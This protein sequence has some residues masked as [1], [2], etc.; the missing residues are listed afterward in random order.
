[1][2][3]SISKSLFIGLG[4]TGTK[5]VLNAKARFLKAYGK[6]V[7]PMVHF[8]A[9]D[10]SDKD[11]YMVDEN[12]TKIELVDDIEFF[13]LQVDN[14]IKFVH[15]NDEVREEFPIENINFYKETAIRQGA[16]QIR[17]M[18]R[19]SFI[20][21]YDKI[22]KA[23]NA[24][25]NRISSWKAQDNDNF[26]SS[27]NPLQISLV[28]SVAGGSGSGMFLD[29]AYLLKQEL[30]PKDSHLSLRA[31]ILLPDVYLNK[32]NVAQVK[33]NSYAAIKELEF[34]MDSSFFQNDFK[35]K[36]PAGQETIIDD[37][38]PFPFDKIILVNNTND[39]L[40]SFNEPDEI[41]QLI[42]SVLH[43]TSD[44][45]DT[46]AGVWENAAG[47][48]TNA[49]PINNKLRRYLGLGLC[50]IVYDGEK[51]KNLSA[52]YNAKIIVE[53][54]QQNNS[55]ISGDTNLEAKLN[56][57][58]LNEYNESD[59]VIERLLPKVD[60]G[61]V[62]PVEPIEKGKLP[63]LISNSD[64]FLN[65]Y[66]DKAKKIIEGNFESM[67]TEALGSIKSYLSS[68]ILQNQ[69][70][71]GTVIG[72]T[73]KLIDRFKVFQDQLKNEEKTF[74]DK[75]VALKPQYESIKTEIGN[76]E[77]QTHIPFFN[78]IAKSLEPE[79]ESYNALT[80]KEAEF[81][82]EKFKREY[83]QKFFGSLITEFEST[84]RK[85]DAINADNFSKIISSIDAQINK[86]RNTRTTLPFILNLH[87]KLFQAVTLSKT[88]LS[89]PDF[90]NY[91]K[92]T[93]QGI[94]KWSALTSDA[95]KELIVNY[96]AEEES[97]K[98]WGERVVDEVLLTEFNLKE[99]NNI[100]S[101]AITRSS[102]FWQVRMD[103]LHAL[104]VQFICGLYNSSPNNPDCLLNQDIFKKTDVSKTLLT[105][106]VKR[107]TTGDPTRITIM[108][109]AFCS[110][111]FTVFNMEGYKYEYMKNLAKE[112]T[113][114]RLNHHANTRLQ[115]LMDKDSYDVFPKDI[116][117]EGMAMGAWIIGHLL[118]YLRKI[119][120]YY[121]YQSPMKRQKENGPE[122]WFTFD[123]SER[124]VAFDNFVNNH[125]L[126]N[127]FY[128][129][130]NEW[131][132]KNGNDKFR[133]I[134]DNLI[135]TDESGNRK[136]DDAKFFIDYGHYGINIKTLKG[137]KPYA[138]DLALFGRETNFM[139]NELE[140]WIK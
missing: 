42:S 16:G 123:T 138:Q 65:S 99:V 93:N 39:A 91:L 113:E 6:E 98:K 110:P 128:N 12:D 81:I 118:G 14:A 35:L 26:I 11:K 1:M 61:G 68:E 37:T 27:K 137:N 89:V 15:E 10:T 18:G 109:I 90:L 87:E 5:A 136:I 96:C 134:I 13:H 127:E 30:M 130:K 53:A 25:Y 102:P 59:Q 40:L 51:V 36:Y 100:I 67:I 75:I 85:Y 48:E 135:L 60:A 72:F 111:A 139:L 83:G 97:S 31:F 58:K 106:S 55:G 79:F 115:R 69:N 125:E 82:K 62:S 70:A 52:L 50:E 73:S 131:V 129:M 34:L 74:S 119:A 32:M 38:N 107:T 2:T 112:E 86:I 54:L 44:G 114:Y 108:Q 126:V 3:N 19:I 120:S 63:D 29:F 49:H 56:D 64:R 46:V 76:I 77:K 8:L 80:R 24:A 95:I 7:P 104:D 101:T 41:S 71:T 92:T 57:W 117:N 122:D 84:N 88:S 4:G 28:F 45:A 20:R 66:R 9:F 94:E 105:D 116:R 47:S 121:E 33:P 21:N 133:A 23:I 17:A 140:E 103:I 22:K 124:K 132:K 78:N 43:T